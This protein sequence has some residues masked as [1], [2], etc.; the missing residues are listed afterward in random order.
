MTRALDPIDAER[1][2]DL[3]ARRLGLS[4]EDSKLGQLSELLG[5]RLDSMGMTSG[6]Y[7]DEVDGAEA[8]R[9]ELRAL[10]EEM[11]VTETYFFRNR[12]QFNAFE[13]VVL[14]GRSATISGQS[15]L[16]VLSAGCAS[17]EE[18]YSLAIALREHSV[19]ASGLGASVRGLD[20]NPAALERARRARFSPWSLRETPAEM[21]ARWFRCSG[22][23]YVLDDGIRAMVSFEERNLIED[24]PA[25]WRPNSFDAVFCR[26]VM[27]YFTPAHAQALVERIASALVPG[28]YLFLGHAET[29][30]GL[31][32]EFSLCHSHGTFYYRRKDGDAP[33]T[34][35][36]SRALADPVRRSR[37]APL[38][39]AVEGAGSWV[40]AIHNATERIRRLSQKAPSREVPVERA[41]RAAARPR[42]VDGIR[43]AVE[44]LQEER[45]VDALALIRDLPAELGDDA[46]VLLLRAVLLTHKGAVTEAAE[47]CR[48]LLAI[49]GMNAGAHYL[50]ALCREAC[51]DRGRAI[52]HD[53]IA[54]YLDPSFAMPRLHLGL[55]ARQ[56]SDLSRAQ[57]EFEA[58]IVLLQRED[59]ARLLLFGGGFGREAL[60]ALCRAELS[61]SGGRS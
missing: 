25:L 18:P 5:R 10:A 22:R 20:V 23:E 42:G 30:R 48:K 13:D 2:R 43:R 54:G 26:N 34:G 57:R 61:T 12:E 58:A 44:L 33:V 49:D 60:I 21:Q 38:I 52:E 27:M 50:M 47:V 14:R 9:G 39:S 17:G 3:I 55:L 56:A 37:A 1:F 32:Q 51:G 59:S 8:G 16:R 35:T 31:S 36:V 53:R 6:A 4:F 15:P 41:D 11:T 29:L 7:M 45:F 28:G 24:D 46:E 19:G 40:E